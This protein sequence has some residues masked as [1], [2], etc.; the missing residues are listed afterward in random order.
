MLAS[1]PLWLDRRCMDSVPAVMT[2]SRCLQVQAKNR[3][4]GAGFTDLEISMQVLLSFV[5][6]PLMLNL[7][8]MGDLCTTGSWHGLAQLQPC[9]PACC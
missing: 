7:V 1:A 9:L 2:P 5:Y 6:L 8:Y 3:S 4:T